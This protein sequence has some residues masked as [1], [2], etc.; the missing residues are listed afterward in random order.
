MS[1]I[2]ELPH[3][4]SRSRIS[5]GIGKNTSHS[6]EHKK[7]PSPF[8]PELQPELSP[9]PL[10]VTLCSIQLGS[11]KGTKQDRVAKTTG[12]RDHS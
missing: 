8:S 6:R 11:E 7:L 10:P 9:H 3:L 4:P 2:K 1:C 12:L 5:M